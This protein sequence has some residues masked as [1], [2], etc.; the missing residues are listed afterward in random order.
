MFDVCFSSRA[1]FHPFLLLHPNMFSCIG[2]KP[3]CDPVFIVFF[4][5]MENNSPKFN[6]EIGN[7]SDS[8]EE[9][10]LDKSFVTDEEVENTPLTMEI[11][12]SKSES[13]SVSVH[14]VNEE[15]I[16]NEFSLT[17]WSSNYAIAYVIRLMHCL[18]FSVPALLKMS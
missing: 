6:H 14:S 9:D 11:Q 4:L 8:D 18:L 1:I 12:S 3:S 15:P 2:N 5:D 16:S 13:V 10:S 7:D 17:Y